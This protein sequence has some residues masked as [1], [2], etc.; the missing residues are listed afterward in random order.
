VP[1]VS[2]CGSVRERCTRDGLVSLLATST[3]QLTMSIDSFGAQASWLLARRRL[4][5]EHGHRVHSDHADATVRMR[6]PSRSMWYDG[7]VGGSTSNKDR[8]WHGVRV[9]MPG[10]SKTFC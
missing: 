8:R 1:S 2:A 4:L 7:V 3:G 5:G 9:Q 10:T 6:R